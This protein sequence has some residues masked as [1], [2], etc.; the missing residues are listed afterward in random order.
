MI[1]CANC[2][3]WFHPNCLRVVGGQIPSEF[4][5]EFCMTSDDRI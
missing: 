5:C 2:R 3:E 1:K 4:V